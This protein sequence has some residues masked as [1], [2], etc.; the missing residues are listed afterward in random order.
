M[1]DIATN[2][3]LCRNALVICSLGVPVVSGICVAQDAQ[4]A[5]EHTDDASVQL[6]ERLAGAWEL[7]EWTRQAEGADP[8]YPWGEDAQGMLTYDKSGNMSAQLMQADRAPFASD[9]LQEATAAE[10]AAAFGSFFAYFGTYTIDLDAKTI[11]HHVRGSSF[12][13]WT[14]TNQV[15]HFAFEDDQLILS[16]PPIVEGGVARVHR[17]AWKRLPVVV[18]D[19]RRFRRRSVRSESMLGAQSF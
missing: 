10:I 3:R 15:R 16:T 11:T 1:T 8:E 12:P 4:T 17:L 7:V 6:R 5:P 18:V 2:R 19:R 9:D 14:G 13:N